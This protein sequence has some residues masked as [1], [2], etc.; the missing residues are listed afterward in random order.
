MDLMKRCHRHLKN[1]CSRQTRQIALCIRDAET[2]EMK[3]NGGCSFY[4]CSLINIYIQLNTAV[5]TL[6]GSHTPQR[7][8]MGLL[9]P[10]NP[11]HQIS[12]AQLNPDS[13]QNQPFFSQIQPL[14]RILIYTQYSN[15]SP[16]TC[17]T[18]AFKEEGLKVLSYK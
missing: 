8:K 4:H 5:M 18:A 9:T 1:C 13:G 11:V 15:L 14:P 6:C 17:T 12:L 7:R 16:L 3:G 2:K 10:L